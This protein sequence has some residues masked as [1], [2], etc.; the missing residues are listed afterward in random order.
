[1]RRIARDRID[2]GKLAVMTVL[3]NAF[4]II[5]AVFIA[6]LVLYDPGLL[7]N[8]YTKLLT[9]FVLLIVCWGAYYDIREALAARR[10][11]DE[12]DMLKQSL[13][14]LEK[15]NFE[16]R[17]QRHDFM[18]HLQV[19]YSLTEL[20][21]GDEALKYID[22]VHK[23][24]ARVGSALKTAHPAINAL[25][26]AKKHDALERRI[27]FTLICDTALDHLPVPAWEACRAIGNLIDNAFDAL[28]DTRPASVQVQLEETEKSYLFTV[29]NNGP[30]IPPEVLSRIFDAGFST[31]GENRGMGLSIVSDIA[32]TAGGGLYVDTKPGATAFRIELPKPG[33]TNEP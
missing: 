26:S 9:L 11:D 31:K 14:N 22:S 8:L 2:V 27:A 7:G 29:S 19:I 32:A 23:D 6:V 20:Q 28:R 1:M 15:L 12:A 18:N 33:L 13:L 21:E 5:A 3:V 17:K 16:M 24:I 10:L 4:Q 25:I 30:E